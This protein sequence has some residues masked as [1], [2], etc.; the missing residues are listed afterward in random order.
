MA[1]K[2]RTK[3]SVYLDANDVELIKSLFEAANYKP[4]LSGFF[5]NYAN[6]FADHIREAE[7]NETIIDMIEYW[8]KQT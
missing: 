7:E 6:E 4:G 8:E 2:G 5:N 1:I 3:Y